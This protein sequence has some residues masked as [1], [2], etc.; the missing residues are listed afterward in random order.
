MIPLAWN[1]LS[2]LVC[3]IF[4]AVNRIRFAEKAL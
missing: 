3:R 2:L 1:H 4:L